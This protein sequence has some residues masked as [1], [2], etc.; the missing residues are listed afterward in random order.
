ML[1]QVLLNRRFAK[2]ILTG[3]DVKPWS[4]ADTWPVARVEVPRLYK[5]AI[6]LAGASGQSLAFGP[7][8]WS[9]RRRLVSRARRSIPPTAIPISLFSEMW[10][11]ATKFW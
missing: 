2:S 3:R 9:A 4:W 7:G 1:A 10:L 5:S 6:V 8:H 11:P